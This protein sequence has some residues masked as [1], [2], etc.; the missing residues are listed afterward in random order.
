MSV[1]ARCP[2]VVT[3]AALLCSVT[4]ATLSGGCSETTPDFDLAGARRATLTVVVREV[5]SFRDFR[6]LKEVR[7]GLRGAPASMGSADRAGA[8]QLDTKIIWLRRPK[9]SSPGSIL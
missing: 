1:A 8:V 6:P 2:R 9:V 3:A 7:F 5:V 4:G